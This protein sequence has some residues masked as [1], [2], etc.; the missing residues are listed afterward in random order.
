MKIKCS[1]LKTETTED[2][3][4]ILQKENVPRFL[5]LKK[6]EEKYKFIVKEVS[7]ETREFLDQTLIQF[8]Q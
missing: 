3:I 5:D 6:R 1:F 8:N 4:N 2:T 7:D